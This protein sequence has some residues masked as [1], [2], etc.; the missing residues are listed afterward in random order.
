ML[1]SFLLAAVLLSAAPVSSLPQ[2]TADVGVPGL[3]EGGGWGSGLQQPSCQTIP[4]NM[5]LCR[6]IGYSQMRLPNLLGHETMTEVLE[7]GR[8][9]VPLLNQRCHPDAQLLLCSLF[10]PL[11]LDRDIP[12][13]RSLCTAVRDKCSSRMLQF[14]FSWPPMLNCSK[15]PVDNDL[16]VKQQADQTNT[17]VHQLNKNGGPVV[18]QEPPSNMCVACSQPLTEDNIKQYF[19]RAD[20]VVRGRIGRILPKKLKLRGKVSFIKRQ[21]EK[22]SRVRERRPWFQWNRETD[23]CRNLGANDGAKYLIMAEKNGPH[24]APTFIAPWKLNKKMRGL[25]EQ[26]SQLD[27]SNVIPIKVDTTTAVPTTT[28]TKTE[29]PRHGR[30]KK[31]PRNRNHRRKGQARRNRG[32]KRKNNGNQTRNHDRQRKIRNKMRN[33]SRNRQ[34]VE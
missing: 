26:L 28:T 24:W 1:A 33:T 15:Y 6:D 8:Y 22:S 21:E 19:C 4:A 29:P 30:R 14:G 27:C 17:G 18:I 34:M 25:R 2:T 32:G 9:W 23:C 31:K 20:L 13:C 7:Q 3:D 10:T 11:C 16:C 12:P 5:S